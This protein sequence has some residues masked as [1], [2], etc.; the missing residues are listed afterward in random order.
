MSYQNTTVLDLTTVA[1]C[2]GIGSR[3]RLGPGAFN[4]WSNSFPGED[5]PLGRDVR[6]GD[7]PFRFPAADGHRPDNVRCRAQ[8]LE[9]SARGVRVDWIHLLAA[10][11]RRSEDELTVHYRDGS[12][13]SQWLR[14]SDF[15]P[16]TAARFGERMAYRA[17][18]LLYPR[19]EQHGMAPV[20]WAQRVP[21]AV[22][23][24][25]TALTLPDDP[26][27]HLFAVTLVGA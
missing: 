22:P 14:V 6:L 5:L 12:R 20:I 1:D 16:E 24:G 13:R 10:A 15:W 27:V 3:D 19:H 18:S 17:S 23:D 25:V 2:T 8:R 26:A 4:I 21:V 9:V 7:V 11:E